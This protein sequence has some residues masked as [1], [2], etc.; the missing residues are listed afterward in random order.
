MEKREFSLID[1]QQLLK[2]RWWIILLAAIV[3]ACGGGLYSYFTYEPT[4]SSSVTL[5]VNVQTV[6]NDS[7]SDEVSQVN[8]AL[9]VVTNYL[10][11]L[12]TNDFMEEISDTYKEKF[13]KAWEQKTYSATKLAS[14]CVQYTA[15]EDTYL[16]TFTVTTHDKNVSRNIGEIFED[17]APKKILE[18]TGKDAIKV[19]DGARTA[20]TPS[21]SR[22]MMR[23]AIMGFIIGAVLSF[24]IVLIID[25]SDVRIKDE[26]DI[27]DN[28]NVP[29]LGSV[30]N[31]ESAKKKGYGYGYGKK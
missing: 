1:I 2:V 7:A 12:K 26:D 5:Y 14:K 28:Y 10:E 3:F 25:I 11:I 23:N 31:F 21:N 6:Q 29:L 13:P 24:L 30:P 22:N 19:A 4:Y 8:W 17:L 27:I 15:I 20:E 9:K 16:F 18:I